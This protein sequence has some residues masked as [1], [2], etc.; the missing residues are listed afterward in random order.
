VTQALAHLRPLAGGTDIDLPA[1]QRAAGDL[2]P[3]ARTVTSAL[4]GRLRDDM[5]TRQEFLSLTGG[6]RV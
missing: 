6:N 5:R 1:A 2:K 4:H 3:G